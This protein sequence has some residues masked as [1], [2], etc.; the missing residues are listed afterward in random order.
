MQHRMKEFQMDQTAVDKVLTENQVGHIATIG[1]DGFPYVAPVFFLYQNGKIYF[2]GLKAGQKL[3]NI[4]SNA[5]VGFETEEFSEV[6]KEDLD[7]PCDADAVYQSVVVRGNARILDDV[8]EKEKIL[9]TILKK[10]APEYEKTPLSEARIRGTAVVEITP[11]EV[12]GKYH[13]R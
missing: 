7:C 8:T 10:Y 5:A 4:K 3:N 9:R 6:I 13:T 11:V 12:T 2:H 1:A